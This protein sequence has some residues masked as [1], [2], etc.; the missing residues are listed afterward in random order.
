MVWVR[1][2]EAKPFEFDKFNGAHIFVNANA[3]LTIKLSSSHK[4]DRSKKL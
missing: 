4:P 3:F 1:G 2:V